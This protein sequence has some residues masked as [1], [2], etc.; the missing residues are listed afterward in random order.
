[1]VVER[2]EKRI[3]EENP[4]KTL[5]IEIRR[6]HHAIR[7]A[8]FDVQFVENAVEISRAARCFRG[9]L[10]VDQPFGVLGLEIIVGIAEKR[11][12][13]GDKF[14]IVSRRRSNVL[15]SGG[16]A[17]ASTSESSGNVACA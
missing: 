9:F 6:H 15:S 16:A 4:V 5:G 7:Q 10:F 11:F 1:M 3:A 14:G 13:R 2:K 12:R 8:D 17:M